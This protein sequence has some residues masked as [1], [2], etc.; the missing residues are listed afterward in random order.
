[1]FSTRQATLPGAFLVTLVTMTIVASSGSLP[2]RA[3][4]DQTATVAQIDADC[5]AIQNA[6]MALKPIHVLYENS[7]W[8]VVSDA[9]AAVAERTRAS[10]GLFDVW[11]QDKNYAWIRG[12]SFDS[13]GTERATQLCY[14]QSD[15][16]LERAKQA[17]TMPSLDAASAQQAYFANDGTVLTQTKVFEINDPL[18]AKQIE[19]LPFYKVLPQ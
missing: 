13:R 10:I 3:A 5:L 4:G 1:M 17:T 16:S 12:H 2:A 19:A 7:T 15:G 18:I 11:K 8:K 6:V 14:R 9:D